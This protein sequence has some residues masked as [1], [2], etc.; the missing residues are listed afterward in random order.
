MAVG[1]E[2]VSVRLGGAV[3]DI[4]LGVVAI[5]VERIGL[6]QRPPLA[7]TGGGKHHVHEEGILIDKMSPAVGFGAVA[8]GKALSEGVAA[9]GHDAGRLPIEVQ[10]REAGQ[11]G[12]V[13]QIL[14]IGANGRPKVAAIEI[15]L[16]GDAQLINGQNRAAADNRAAAVT[17]QHRIDALAGG[18]D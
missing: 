16:A 7:A 12:G 9:K 5:V 8:H 11:G 4:E 14:Q 10:H 15:P 1:A 2:A 18:A 17:D 6:E 13:G 3:A